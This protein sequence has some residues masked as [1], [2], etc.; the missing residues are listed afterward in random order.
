MPS[1]FSTDKLDQSISDRHLKFEQERQDLLKKIKQWLDQYGEQ[2]GINCAYIFGSVTR[3]Y[4]FHGKSD[5]DLAVETINQD[6]FCLVISLLSEYL[7]REVDV[8]QLR[9]CHFADRI[10]HTA[11]LW[12]KTP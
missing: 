5:I 10:R 3:P 9:N 12:T 8:I 7:E 4:H 1:S 11:I 2:Y 6:K